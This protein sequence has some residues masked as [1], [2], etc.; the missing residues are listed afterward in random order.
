MFGPHSRCNYLDEDKRIIIGAYPRDEDI[1]AII[2]SGVTVFINLTEQNDY[3]LNENILRLHYPIKSGSVPSMKKMNEINEIVN[4][5]LNKNHK[6]Y[7]HCT[8]GHGRA[9]VIASVIIGRIKKMDAC[10]AIHYVESCRNEREDKSRNF[11][12]V[13]ETNAQ[14]NFI[15]KILGYEGKILPDRSDTSWLK[16]VKKER[17]KIDD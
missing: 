1:S 9:S 16:R 8:G 6:I 11:I 10:E 7:I 12:P 4:D 13:P 14:V 2:Q 15:G 5:L 3:N 17:I